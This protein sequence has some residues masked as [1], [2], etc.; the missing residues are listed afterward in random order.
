MFRGNVPG[1]RHLNP[2]SSELGTYVH[3]YP[4]SPV[5]GRSEITLVYNVAAARFAG[6]EHI[7]YRRFYIVEGAMNVFVIAYVARVNRKRLQG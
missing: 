7:P 5:I 4:S 3:P 6:T 2:C 1:A